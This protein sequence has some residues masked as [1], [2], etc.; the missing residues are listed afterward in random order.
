M[1]SRGRHC[2]TAMALHDRE[3]RHASSGGLDP[4]GLAR[5]GRR[6]AIGPSAANRGRGEATHRGPGGSAGDSN[7]VSDTGFGLDARASLSALTPV[8]AESLRGG[9]NIALGSS[10]F[11]QGGGDVVSKSHL[12][13]ILLDATFQVDGETLV[14]KGQVVSDK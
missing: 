8:D 12:D 1:R 2:D 10:M 7:H 11:P 4:P 9:V 3:R 14:S 5:G 13:A 6:G